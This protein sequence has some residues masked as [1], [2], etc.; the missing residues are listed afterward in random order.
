[1]PPLQTTSHL[2]RGGRHDMPPLQTTRHLVRTGERSYL[3][4]FS[5]HVPYPILCPTTNVL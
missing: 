5:A 3:S 1:M 2:V 4:K